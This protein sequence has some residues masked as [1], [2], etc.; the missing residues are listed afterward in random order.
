VTRNTALRLLALLLTTICS[1]CLAIDAELGIG[2]LFVGRELSTV[3]L[4]KSLIVLFGS[5]PAD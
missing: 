3:L 5:G 1:D 2:G 4:G